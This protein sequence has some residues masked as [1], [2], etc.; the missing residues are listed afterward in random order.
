MLC[1]ETG[2]SSASV[3]QCHRKPDIAYITPLFVIANTREA[4]HIVCPRHYHLSILRGD[5]ESKDLA[6]S[7]DRDVRFPIRRMCDY[8]QVEYH[9]NHLR[10][11]VRAWCTK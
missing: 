9:C 7:Y 8:T 3:P 2:V 11:I 10:Y 1:K 4:V 5:L 6:A